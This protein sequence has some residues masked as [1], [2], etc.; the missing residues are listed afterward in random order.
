MKNSTS[1]KILPVQNN[2]LNQDYSTYFNANNYQYF[3]NFQPKQSLKRQVSSALLSVKNNLLNNTQQI[4]AQQQQYPQIQ[5]QQQQQQIPLV[6]ID[7]QNTQPLILPTK[8]EP[9]IIRIQKKIYKRNTNQ[10][11]LPILM[12][13]RS[14]D[15][16]GNL[17]RN[18]TMDNIS[19]NNNYNNNKNII[20][21]D[22]NN[23]ALTNNNQ[24]TDLT[25]N[26]YEITSPVKKNKFISYIPINEKYFQDS[27]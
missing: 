5:I 27:L 7:L 10:K 16:F 20:Y 13:S 26:E 4:Q 17:M 9:K 12:P 23:L 3:D 24:I 8:S 2:Y 14:V 25:S 22:K 19:Y 15:N 6:E 18:I 1:M 11:N 21:D